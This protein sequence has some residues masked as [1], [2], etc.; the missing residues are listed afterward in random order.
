MD[1]VAKAMQAPS[2]TRPRR[3]RKEEVVIGRM[4]LA[5]AV[6]KGDVTVSQAASALGCPVGNVYGLLASAIYTAWNRGLVE[7]KEVPR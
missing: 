6:H 7:I 1:L 2:S 4:R 5:L 3:M